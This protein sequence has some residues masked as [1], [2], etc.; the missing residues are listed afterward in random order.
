[1]QS[2]IIPDYDNKLKNLKPEVIYNKIKRRGGGLSDIAV[3]IVI[4]PLNT[5]II[6][7]LP[8]FNIAQY[9]LQSL[10]STQKLPDT[11][12]WIH[13]NPSDSQDILFKKSIFPTPDN[14]YL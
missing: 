14:Q 10:R 1:M 7:S 5:N 3:P 11:F 13:T 8:S 2:L 6:F 12:D 9:P 4:P